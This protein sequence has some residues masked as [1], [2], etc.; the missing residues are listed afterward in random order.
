MKL[1]VT[2]IL[3][4]LADFGTTVGVIS[5]GGEEKNPIVGGLMGFGTWEGLAI[6][7]LIALAFGTL[8]LFSGRYSGLRK[9]N[10]AFMAVVA[11][12]LSII[13]RLMLA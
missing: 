5:L 12:N 9:I 3:L 1:F 7:K 11:W 2:F 8:A 10:I 4:Q 13:G 6:A